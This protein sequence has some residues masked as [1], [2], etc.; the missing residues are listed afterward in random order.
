MKRTLSRIRK[1]NSYHIFSRLSRGSP[2]F[3][4]TPR[5]TLII[6]PHPDDETLGCG[7][8]IALK[9]DQNTPVHILFLTAGEKGPGPATS[10]A[11]IRRAETCTA[12]PH[13]GLCESDATF[14]N[15]PDSGLASLSPQDQ[16]SLITRVT[17]LI[18][19]VHIEEIFVTHR[20]DA[21]P[22][23]EAAFQLTRAATKNASVTLWQYPI[24]FAWLNSLRTRLQPAQSHG[25]H[26]LDITPALARKK[27]A[28]A[29]YASQIAAFPPGF[30]ARFESPMEIFF[31]APLAI[32]PPATPAGES[33]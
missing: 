19:K 13:L 28:L 17:A 16:Q 10:L 26:V 18:A 30:L 32:Q 8:L 25:A 15:F 3:I 21:H 33:L 4:L 29:A 2:S 5:P 22:D 14:W 1:T 31:A 24:W 11:A 6:A 27:L 23:H 12:L 20:A 7:G 9:R